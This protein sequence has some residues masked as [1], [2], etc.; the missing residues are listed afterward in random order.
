MR[1]VKYRFANKKQSYWIM[2]SAFSDH[3]FIYQH[4]YL[5]YE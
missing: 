4:C 1:I 5:L 2:L 3:L